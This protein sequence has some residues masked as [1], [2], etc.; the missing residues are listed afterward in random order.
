[1]KELKDI[2][3]DIISAVF[4]MFKDFEISFDN[5]DPMAVLAMFMYSTELFVFVLAVFLWV[6]SVFFKTSDKWGIKEQKEKRRN[7]SDKSYDYHGSDMKQMNKTHKMGNIHEM[8]NMHKMK[9]ERGFLSV[10]ITK[11][12]FPVAAVFIALM[13]VINLSG[14]G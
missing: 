7:G 3:S 12:V 13:V 11:F 9:Q 10:F 4:N 8:G 6:G 1:M 2:S 14:F 5:D